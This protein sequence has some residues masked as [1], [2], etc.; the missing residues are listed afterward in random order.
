MESSP[1]R[2]QIL[3]QWG[4]RRG[5]KESPNTGRG[6]DWQVPRQLFYLTERCNLAA[7]AGQTQGRT[8]VVSR[9]FHLSGI[10]VSVSGTLGVGLQ[11]HVPP[12]YLTH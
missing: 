1:D 6:L 11:I 7:L 3:L 5:K 12:Q 2:V 9:C 10:T 4:G 8:D